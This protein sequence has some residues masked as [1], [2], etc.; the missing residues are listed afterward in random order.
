LVDKDL[1]DSVVRVKRKSDRIM[2]IQVVVGLEILNVV[3]VYTPQIGLL[4]DIKKQF[5][6]DLDM[7]I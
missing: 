2:T 5:G 3:S 7:I 4:E 1:V 6:E